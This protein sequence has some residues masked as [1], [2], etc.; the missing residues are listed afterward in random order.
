VG[1]SLVHLRHELADEHHANV[2]DRLAFLAATLH[3]QGDLVDMRISLAIPRRTQARNPSV[4]Q[5][6]KGVPPMPR[7]PITKAQVAK[8]QAARKTTA[9]DRQAAL[10]AL[11][12]NAQFTTPSSGPR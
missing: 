7:G 9:Q 5:R 2:G 12:G 6:T 1:Q 10:E 3:E 4:L 11:Q 8:M